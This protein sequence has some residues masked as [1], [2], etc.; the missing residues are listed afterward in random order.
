MCGNHCARYI[1]Q[2]V[3]WPDSYTRLLYME[4]NTQSFIG[5]GGFCAHERGAKSER[6]VMCITPMQMTEPLGTSPSLRKD[7]SPLWLLWC[8]CNSLCKSF[9]ADTSTFFFYP[10]RSRHITYS[11]TNTHSSTFIWKCLFAQWIY[12]I[13]VTEFC[14]L[15]LCSVKF[16]TTALMRFVRGKCQSAWDR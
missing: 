4:S 5:I 9:Q 16:D 8:V 14:F 11:R 6:P 10:R 12:F 2:I 7:H 3:Q 13:F 15:F 1:R